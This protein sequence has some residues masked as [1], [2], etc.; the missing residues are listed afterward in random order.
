MSLTLDI[1][2]IC[3][4]YVEA[5]HSHNKVEDSTVSYN[6]PN[7]PCDNIDINGTLSEFNELSVLMVSKDVQAVFWLE[8]YLL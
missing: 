4:M 1:V 3:S 8:C 6:E 2:H 5:N 7:Q